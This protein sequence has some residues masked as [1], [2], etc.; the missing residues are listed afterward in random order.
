[1]LNITSVLSMLGVATFVAIAPLKVASAW[2]YSSGYGHGSYGHYD[3]DGYG[4]HHK[5]HAYYGHGRHYKPYRHHKSRYSNNVRK[6]CRSTHKYRYD[7]YGN[8]V[9]VNGTLCYNRYGDAY[10]VPGSRYV[11]DDYYR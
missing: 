1:M 11:V 9:R 3:H 7:D 6:H 4:K 10:I 2:D 8:K 5:R